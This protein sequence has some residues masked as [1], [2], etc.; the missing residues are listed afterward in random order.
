ML[1]AATLLS[2]M[3]L[4]APAFADVPRTPSPAPSAVSGCDPNAA[5]TSLRS[6]DE[7]VQEGYVCLARVADGATRVLDALNQLES[8][9][10]PQEPITLTDADEGGLAGLDPTRP[11][12]V[13]ARYT[14]AL[15]LWLLEHADVEMDGQ[16]VRRLAPADRRL[17]E[18]GIKARR[19]RPSLSS[20]NVKVFEKLGWYRPDP[21][22]T[23][24]RLTDVDRA[25]LAV[26][27]N[28][29]PPP[30]PPPKPTPDTKPMSEGAPTQ[31]G[32]KAEAGPS[33]GC[34]CNSG[35]DWGM[36]CIVAVLTIIGIMFFHKMRTPPPE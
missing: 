18:D 32:P 29:P 8:S 28:P 2:L 19:G 6:Y 20:D 31:R 27:L 35:G 34:G 13:H 11:S 10:P 24:N 4:G 9:T 7:G 12:A 22:Y 23:D 15:G 25:N 36:S 30:A 3:L 5:L 21:R 1:L 14:R 33:A 26:V 17:L 16:L